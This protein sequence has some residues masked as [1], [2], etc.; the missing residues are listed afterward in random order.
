MTMTVDGEQLSAG[1]GADCLG[2]PLNALVWLARM[3]IEVGTPLR[4]GQVVLSGALGPMVAVSPGA[5]VRA[6]I[7][8][9]GAVEAAFTDG[10]SR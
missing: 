2:D 7:T 6:E 3:A 9:L 10:V 1:R 8:G 5:R 4:A